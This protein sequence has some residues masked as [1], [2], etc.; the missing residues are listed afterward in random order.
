M[1]DEGS[2]CGSC[3]Q[4]HCVD[5]TG[6]LILPNQTIQPEPCRKQKCVPGENGKVGLLNEN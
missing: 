4:T 6:Q 3:L 5:A 1:S 2:C